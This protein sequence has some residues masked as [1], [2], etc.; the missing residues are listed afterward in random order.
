M[1]TKLS[2]G[3][4]TANWNRRAFCLIGS[5]LFYAKD[6][7][8]LNVQPKIFAEISG[9]EVRPF[10]DDGS[11]H[12]NVLAVR[13]PVPGSDEGFEMLLLAADT[14]REKYAWIDAITR[15][16][17]MPQCPITQVASSLSVAAAYGGL[18]DGTLNSVLQAEPD[19]TL[20]VAPMGEN[21]GVS[22]AGYTPHAAAQ[23]QV[24]VE[25]FDPE[26]SPWTLEKWMPDFLKNV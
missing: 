19:T 6:R 13:L 10:A 8:T 21:L 7:A 23:K 9:C 22:D 12:S 24:S 11:G 25:A 3:G 4:F 2:K 14:P 20:G 18:H 26:D 1:L 16:S 17:H 15:G 5:S